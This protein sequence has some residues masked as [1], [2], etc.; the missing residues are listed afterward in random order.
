MQGGGAVTGLVLSELTQGYPII[1]KISAWGPQLQSF[2]TFLR[3]GNSANPVNA[4]AWLSAV[5]QFFKSLYDSTSDSLTKAGTSVLPLLQWIK[6]T[7]TSFNWEDVTNFKA[8]FSDVEELKSLLSNLYS[9]SPQ[10][11]EFLSDD[12]KSKKLKDLFDDEK[13]TK[14]KEALKILSG[15]SSGSFRVEPGVAVRLANEL[16]K[17]PEKVSEKIDRFV[18][19]LD[20]ASQTKSTKPS[21]TDGGGQSSA[22]GIYTLTKEKLSD[23]LDERGD[24][25]QAGWEG[26][27]LLEVGVKQQGYDL[28]SV[29]SKAAET[30]FSV[31]SWW[32]NN[33]SASHQ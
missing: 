33:S 25:A 3:G 15:T 12:S 9:K 11:I 28:G 23:F 29:P 10:F 7:H 17:A 5:P 32:F 8:A 22:S 20:K 30:I 18:E 27:F 13:L 14:T 24:A 6:E 26:G 16:I 2:F 21:S 31:L 19:L 4:W 1:S